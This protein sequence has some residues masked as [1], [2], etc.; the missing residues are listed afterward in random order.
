MEL[1]MITNGEWELAANIIGLALAGSGLDISA[2]DQTELSLLPHSFQKN[3][4]AFW[5]LSIKDNLVGC[6]GVK[7]TGQL[8]Q[9]WE[10]KH[11]SL[12]PAWRRMGLG[13]MMVEK[14]AAHARENG[15]DSLVAKVPASCQA[16]ISLLKSCK[17]ALLD[18]DS[19]QIEGELLLRRDFA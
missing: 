1:R 18:T 7:P 14:A 17:F 15:A 6:V 11:L 13:R 19:A 3:G 2:A 4:G 9:S 10:L 12:V 5:V 16:A 8:T